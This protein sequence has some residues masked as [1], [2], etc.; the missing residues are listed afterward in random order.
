MKAGAGVDPAARGP[1]WIV[2]E[3]ELPALLAR[4]TRSRS[5]GSPWSKEGW[6]H[7]YLLQ[8]PAMAARPRGRRPTQLQR[9]LAAGAYGGPAEHADL[10]RRLVAGLGAGCERVVLGYTLRR[11]PF[12]AEFSKGIENIAWDSQAGLDSEIFVRTA[13]LK[14]FPWNGWMRLGTAT[15]PTA[16]WNPVAGF[17]DPAGRLLWSALGDPAFLPGPYGGEPV[18][19]RAVPASVTGG[20]AAG[21]RSRR[22]RGSRSRA[23]GSCG[24]WAA[25]A[26]PGPRSSIVCGPPPR[27]TTRG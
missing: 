6:F 16:A 20:G 18:P 10:A 13:K 2:E 4:G 23:P 11:E 3:V 5:A 1:E 19:H 12:N 14:D 8:A 27:T 21:S 26:P 15:R 17:T 22:T 7:A 24:R 25:G 9:R